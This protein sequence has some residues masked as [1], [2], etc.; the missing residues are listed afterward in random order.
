MASLIDPTNNLSGVITSIGGRSKASF[1]TAI[2]AAYL[3][4]GRK[5]KSARPSSSP[6][7]A[8]IGR[9]VIRLWSDWGEA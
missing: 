3:A 7:I 2:V 5:P 6:S 4:R 9:T 1:G 8:N